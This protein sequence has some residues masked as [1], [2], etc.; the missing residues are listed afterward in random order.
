MLDRGRRLQ[1]Q[2]LPLNAS[3][4]VR[5][6]AA[7]PAAFPG[8]EGFGARTPGGRGGQVLFVRNLK[9]D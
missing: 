1:P 6:A 9:R 7:G 4:G 2:R 8:A 3:A 5:G